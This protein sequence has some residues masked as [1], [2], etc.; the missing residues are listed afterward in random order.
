M[1]GDLNLGFLGLN[2]TKYYSIKDKVTVHKTRNSEDN[3]T[4]GLG[5]TIGGELGSTEVAAVPPLIH[6]G[7]VNKPW[8]TTNSSLYH[9]SASN[10][11]LYWK[12]PGMW[13]KFPVNFNI[14]E[15]LKSL[16]L[17]S[18]LNLPLQNRFSVGLLH[19]YFMPLSLFILSLLDI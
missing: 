7:S 15:Y 5:P 8:Q 17:K 19:I 11:R 4:D 18:I 13:N 1:S 2:H 6:N 10:C 9:C 3:T 16:I 14:E 12:A